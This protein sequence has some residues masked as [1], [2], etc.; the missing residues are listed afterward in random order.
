MHEN[1][2]ILPIFQEHKDDIVSDVSDF[3]NMKPE[4]KYGHASRASAFM[5]NF[6]EPGVNWLHVDFYGPA[7]LKKAHPPMPLLATGINT[8][9]CLNL[10][11]KLK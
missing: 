1:S 4:D 10:L 5:L 3:R 9:T 2:W 7:H 8:Q 11:R 6:I